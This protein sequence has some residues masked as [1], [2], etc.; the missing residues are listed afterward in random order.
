MVA[1]LNNGGGFYS[2]E[3]YVHEAQMHGGN[4]LQPCI[5]R[6]FGNTII[7]GKDIYIGFGFLQ[8][9]E[10]KLIQKIIIERNKKGVFESLDDFLERIS[11]GMEQVTILIK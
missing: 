1:T 10:S 11:I 4:I 2:V 3:L 6:S 8:S 5:N 7:D 9:L